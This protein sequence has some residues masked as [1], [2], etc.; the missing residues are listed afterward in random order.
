MKWEGQVLN[1]AIN[2]VKGG[3]LQVLVNG[4]AIDISI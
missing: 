2:G 4:K 3:K 1:V